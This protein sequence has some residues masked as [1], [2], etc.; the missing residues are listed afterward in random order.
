MPIAQQKGKITGRTVL[1]SMLAFFGV[2]IAVNLTLAF[3]ALRTDNGLVVR[4]SYVASQDFNREM[5]RARAQEELG[6]RMQAGLA[7][8]VLAVRM[9]DRDGHDLGNLTVTA[10]VGRPVT[11]RDDRTVQLQPRANGYAADLD[12]KPGIWQVE[13]VAADRDGRTYKRIWRFDVEAG[14]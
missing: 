6:W 8:G 1:F 10:K 2:I 14:G 9:Q 7:D 11:A 5:A 13:A 12:L 4:N 3:F